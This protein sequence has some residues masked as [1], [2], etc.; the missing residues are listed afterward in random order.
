MTILQCVE[1][2]NLLKCVNSI[3]CHC[4]CKWFPRFSLSLFCRQCWDPRNSNRP[5]H[6]TAGYFL[7][8]NKF[9]TWIEGCLIRLQHLRGMKGYWEWQVNDKLTWNGTPRN[10]LHDIQS[11]SWT[12]LN[13]TFYAFWPLCSLYNFKPYHAKHMYFLIWNVRIK[14]TG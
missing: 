3:C 12:R 7:F 2:L 1:G 9:H 11:D 6:G 10:P 5:L 13:L 8:G 14:S 4:F